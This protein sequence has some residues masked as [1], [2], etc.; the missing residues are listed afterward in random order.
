M[1]AARL[2]RGALVL[3]LDLPSRFEVAVG[4]P[5]AAVDEAAAGG[6]FEGGWPVE[7]KIL[8]RIRT[9]METRG[10]I[11]LGMKRGAEK[12]AKKGHI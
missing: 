8:Y 12:K 11:R 2:P 7:P 9:G 10:K 1:F 3:L 5:G 6:A 4:E